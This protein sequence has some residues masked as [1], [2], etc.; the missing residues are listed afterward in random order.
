[1][2]GLESHHN[3]HQ[4]VKRFGNGYSATFVETPHGVTWS[5]IDSPQSVRDSEPPEKVIG[6]RKLTQ[7]LGE[8]RSYFKTRT[9][10]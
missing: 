6:R 5:R 4:F 9:K 8:A 7:A 3:E 2:S 10:E 1:M